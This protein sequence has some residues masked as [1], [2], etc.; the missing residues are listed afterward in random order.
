[1]SLNNHS[2]IFNHLKPSVLSKS[3]MAV[4]PVAHRIDLIKP[5]L[6][7]S[8]VTPGLKEIKEDLQ[9][10][11]NSFADQKDNSQQE[12]QQKDIDDQIQEGQSEECE[13]TE[14]DIIVG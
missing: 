3:A 7:E 5:G 4:K 1:M 6:M 14:F 11:Y 12:E 13:N 2:T 10:A 9:F 8:I